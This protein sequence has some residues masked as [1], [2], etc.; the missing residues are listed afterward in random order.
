MFNEMSLYKMSKSE[1]IVL[2]YIMC[3]KIWKLY[4]NC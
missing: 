2:E 3:K 4:E 1:N